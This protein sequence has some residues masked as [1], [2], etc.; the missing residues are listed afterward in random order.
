MLARFDDRILPMDSP[1]AIGAAAAQRRTSVDLKDCLIGAIANRHDMTV[2]TQNTGHL[3]RVANRVM[4]PW[5]E[6]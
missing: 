4:D 6:T 2:V 3:A 5:Q 1:A